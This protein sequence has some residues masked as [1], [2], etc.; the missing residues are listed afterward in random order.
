MTFVVKNLFR[1]KRNNTILCC[2]IYYTSAFSTEILEKLKV[3]GG[4]QFRPSVDDIDFDMDVI[5]LM[6]KCWDEDP[7]YRPT[8]S[9]LRKESRKM[10]W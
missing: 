6:K 2:W 8:F 5:R 9:A 7:K 3:V 10:H 1:K 4:T